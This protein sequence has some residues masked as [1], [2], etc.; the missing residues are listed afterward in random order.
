[1]PRL[2]DT[3]ARWFRYQHLSMSCDDEHPQRCD[4]NSVS[5]Q[6]RLFPTFVQLNGSPGQHF[7]QTLEINMA[8]EIVQLFSHSSA[9]YP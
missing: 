7:E 1:M 9:I 8:T 3:L 6:S 5:L 2:L 4:H